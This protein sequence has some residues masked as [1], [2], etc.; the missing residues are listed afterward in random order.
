MITTTDIIPI[1][2]DLFIA[3][4]NDKTLDMPYRQFTNALVQLIYNYGR[5]SND[6]PVIIEKV[7]NNYKTEI[8]NY[9]QLHFN[10]TNE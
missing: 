8:N 4:W 2:E 3:G 10:A 6:A 1:L 9:V 5:C 7:A